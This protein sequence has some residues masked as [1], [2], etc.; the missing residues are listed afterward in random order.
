[1]RALRRLRAL[2]RQLPLN[3]GR[4]DSEQLSLHYRRIFI[5]PTRYGLFMALVAGLVWL[6]G[7][8]YT[9]NMV[10]LLSFLLVGLLVISI[11]HTFNNLHRLQ[12]HAGPAQPVF[13]GQ[14]LRFP[15]TVHDPAGRE[16][17]AITVDGGEGL[18]TADIPPGESAQWW[19]TVPTRER[20]WR[21]LPR[22]RIQTR[23]PTGLFI[24]WALPSLQQRSLVYP[25]PEPGNVPPPPRGQEGRQGD[26]HGEGDDDFHGL[27]R[28]QV[29]DPKGHIA[30]KR[31]ARGEERVYTKQFAGA[32]GAPRWLDERQLDPA[33]G[34]E[35]RLSR[36][37]RWIIDLD[38]GG[39]PYGLRLG[40][41]QIAPGRG[42][43]HR[44]ACL[45]ALALHGQESSP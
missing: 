43:A 21:P 8:N 19:L 27:R 17:P 28:Y 45:R 42:E 5:L 38:N 34:L 4:S 22:F 40:R 7:V 30:W 35:E 31:L 16:R 9:N 44:H 36:L 10:L 33:L 39:H 2:L 29:G 12:V 6:G 13:A 41:V 37:C 20:G 15:V 26:R 14:P 24:A 18:Q 32:S 1:M 25:S 3:R 11:H 23:F